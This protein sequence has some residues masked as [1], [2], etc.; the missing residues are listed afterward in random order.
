MIERLRTCIQHQAAEA[1]V[2]AGNFDG[3]TVSVTLLSLGKEHALADAET[4]LQ[5]YVLI[6]DVRKTGFTGFTL[7]RCLLPTAKLSRRLRSELVLHACGFTDPSF[8]NLK[9]S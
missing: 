9:T 8:R 3:N 6:S 4:R 2:A 1:V 7:R 5:G